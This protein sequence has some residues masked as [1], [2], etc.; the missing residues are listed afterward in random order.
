MTHPVLMHHS[1][2]YKRELYR[3]IKENLKNI[4]QSFVLD[5]GC[6]RGDDMQVIGGLG[7]EVIVVGLDVELSVLKEAAHKFSSDNRKIV[8]QSNGC[9]LPF[10]D[11]SFDVVSSSEV[12]EHID[13]INA[14]LKEIHRILKPEGVFVITTPSRFNYVTLIGKMIPRKFKNRLRRLAY[15]PKQIEEEVDP[16]VREYLSREMKKIFEDNYLKVEKIKSGALRVPVWSAFDRIPP[17]VYL[18]KCLD[19]VLGIIPGGNNL[20]HQFVLLGRKKKCD[21]MEKI[22]I[23]NLGGIGDF[24]LSTPAIKALRK[25]YP[26]AKIDLLASG[27][28]GKIAGGVD[29]ID[30]VFV[31]DIK[32]GGII[33]WR[34]IWK[35]IITLLSLRKQRFDLAINMRTITSEDSAKKIKFL[36]KIIAAKK[37]AGRNTAG[38][39][40]FFDIK[41]P[42][43]DA[44][45]KYEMKY[46]IDT[47][48]ALGVEVL[49]KQIS[50]EIKSNA[51][52]N[53]DN[54]LKEEQ[55]SKED[56]LI[57]IHP[58]GMPSRRWPIERFAKVVDAISGQ[59]PVKFIITGGKFE[60]VLG[61]T[62]K[63]I[64]D[65]KVINAA[66]NLNIHELF[67]LINRC[68][69]YISNDTGPMHIAAIQKTPLVAILGPGHFIRYDPRNISDKVV[70]L[71]KKKECSPCLK[72]ECDDLQ[73]LKAVSPQEVT[74]AVLKLL[75]KNND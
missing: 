26:E 73:C 29:Y 48:E 74:D 12:I 54:L 5:V 69:V 46:D 4:R 44:G 40:S 75:G 32:Y 33:R 6:R 21:N 59:M 62:L 9:S 23:I 56:I 37:T 65:T 50:L 38:R 22:L 31:F 41:I 16:H 36:L 24:L 10:Q 18:W 53:I 60:E 1:C 43:T 19:F 3:L 57:G 71:Y 72:V 70:V 66:G 25:A 58:G 27:S 42:E 7:K 67:A 63:S 64:S 35:N 11:E 68:N 20:K 52:E 47:V 2:K 45:D 14:F 30:K 8:L 51:Q 17:L 15:H 28:I 61:N 39:A 13:D 34:R 55:I 49:D